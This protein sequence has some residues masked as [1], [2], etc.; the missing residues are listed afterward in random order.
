MITVNNYLTQAAAIDF[1]ALP[2]PLR[3]GDDLARKA[4]LNA[5]QTYNSNDTIKRVVDTYVDKLNAYLSANPQPQE[6]EETPTA[7]AQPRV[8]TK[9]KTAQ[10]K[11]RAAK[12]KAPVKSTPKPVAKPV[13]LIPEEIRFLRRYVAMHGKVKTRI[14]VVRL[15]SSLQKAMIEKRIRKT[16]P[17]AKEIMQMQ[18]QLIKAADR[19]GE[20]A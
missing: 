7:P 15:L 9:A 17:Y 4:L 14:A 5:G 3:K 11:A 1:S 13:E 12:P 2:E 6:E 19:M 16:S 20:A 8:T 10:P 18:D